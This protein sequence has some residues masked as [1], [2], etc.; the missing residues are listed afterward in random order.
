MRLCQIGNNTFAW[1]GKILKHVRHVGRKYEVLGT[2]DPRS[3]TFEG[4][5][6]P[7]MVDAAYAYGILSVIPPQI[8]IDVI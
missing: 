8:T 7:T 5:N 4:M 2:Y 6:E 3:K 1:D